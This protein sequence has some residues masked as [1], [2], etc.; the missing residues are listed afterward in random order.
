MR[1]LSA[2]LLRVDLA[3]GSLSDAFGLMLFFAEHD[4]ERRTSPLIESDVGSN[5]GLRLEVVERAL[6]SLDDNR[7]RY[8]K[9]LR[10]DG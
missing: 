1:N 7:A 6:A 5:G 10:F 2:Y 4:P 8:A 3:G 9:R